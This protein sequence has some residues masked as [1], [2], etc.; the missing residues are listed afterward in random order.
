[1]R[2]ISKPRGGGKTFEIAEWVK[3]GRTLGRK[4][5][6]D[7]ILVV[8]SE[9]QKNIVMRDFNLGHHEVES[10]DTIVNHYYSPSLSIK[11]L[12]L[13]NADDFL[14]HHFKGRL[15]GVS[16]TSHQVD[17]HLPDHVCLEELECSGKDFKKDIK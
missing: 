11:D 6:S 3:Q 2:I 17:Y 10:V 14:Q 7:R 9:E 4:D 12:F 5:T 13:D 15:H 1:M 8:R 16:F